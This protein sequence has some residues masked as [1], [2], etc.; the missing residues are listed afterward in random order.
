MIYGSIAEKTTGL[1]ERVLT[2]VFSLILG[3]LMIALLLW[4]I[5]HVLM[6]LTAVIGAVLSGIVVVIATFGG[7]WEIGKHLIEALKKTDHL[8]D[9]SLPFF[10]K[11]LGLKAATPPP[12]PASVPPSG[13]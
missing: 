13:A 4:I 2:A 8:E 12:P 11:V 5:L 1:M 3:P 9:K 10:K 7:A 6:V